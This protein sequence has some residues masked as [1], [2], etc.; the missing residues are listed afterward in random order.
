MILSSL[1]DWVNELNP[2]EI[3][4]GFILGIIASIVYDFSSEVI[5]SWKRTNRFKLLNGKYIRYWKES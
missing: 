1:K 2:I 3:F 5:K 4:L